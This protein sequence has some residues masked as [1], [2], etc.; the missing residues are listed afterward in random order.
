MDFIKKN[1]EKILLGV[2]LLGLL[3]AVGFMLVVISNEKT[4]L[5]ELTTSVLNPHVKPLTNVDLTM[6]QAAL[7]RVATP[8]MIDFGPPNRLFN[9]MPWQK[10]DRLVPATKVGPNAITATNIQPLFLK[11]T[12]DQVEPS[13]S[14][15]KYLIGIEKQAAPTPA[16]RNKKEAYCKLND[17]DRDNTFQLVEVK[18]KPEDPG[19][20]VV[21]LID[22]GEKATIAKNAEG[23]YD[24]F[25]RVDGY[26]A[27]LYYSIDRKPWPGRRVNS[28][29]PI[30]CNG[31]EYN[32]VAISQTDVVLAA[33]SNGKKW[34]IKGSATP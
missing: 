29:P 8:A 19:A 14:G 9:P 18:G 22:T 31:E 7:K 12:L 11:L 27:D 33:K 23:K 24:P 16:Q 6:P 3:V 1:Y 34:T 17:K 15:Y 21:Q 28:Q 30:S 4:K 20:I 5:S 10:T 32:I 26:T 25:T 2:V 13:D